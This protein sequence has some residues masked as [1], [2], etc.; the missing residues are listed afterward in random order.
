MKRRAKAAVQGVDGGKVIKQ[1][2]EGEG[3][4]SGYQDGLNKMD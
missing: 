2:K 1:E 4:F 3:V